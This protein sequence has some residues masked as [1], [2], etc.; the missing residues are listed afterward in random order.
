M[1]PDQRRPGTLPSLPEWARARQSSADHSS[2]S[3]IGASAGT[4]NNPTMWDMPKT[5]GR[6]RR[7]AARGRTETS[8]PRMP[9][10]FA[11][12]P[13]GTSVPGNF[14]F[15]H[16]VVISVSGA[17]TFAL[18]YNAK[19]VTDTRSEL[20]IRTDKS[21]AVQDGGCLPSP[22]PRRSGP[23]GSNCRRWSRGI[24][25]HRQ[26]TSRQADTAFGLLLMPRWPLIVD[27][28]AAETVD[29]HRRDQANDNQHRQQQQP[30][31]PGRA[32]GKPAH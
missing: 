3:S 2:S 29:L 4:E 30:Q 22:S 17:S 32:Q 28:G 25:A 7:D 18:A 12:S 15:D 23:T 9:E 26:C 27:A 11:R 31:R 8:I 14:E 24:C 10:A 1:L 13:R 21:F 16:G 6:S 5:G 19:S 20:G